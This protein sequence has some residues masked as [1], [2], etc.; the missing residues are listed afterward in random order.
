MLSP[1]MLLS[2]LYFEDNKI[3]IYLVSFIAPYKI[4]NAFAIT[5]FEHVT[6]YP[7]RFNLKFY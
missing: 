3:L 7:I 2:H 6:Q 1:F 5:C 4:S